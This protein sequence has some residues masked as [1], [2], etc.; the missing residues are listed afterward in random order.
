VLRCP[1]RFGTDLPLLALTRGTRLGPY[2]TWAAAQIPST[3]KIVF[4]PTGLGDPIALDR[5]PI[6][7]TDVTIKWFA[8]SSR[9]LYCGREPTM[10]SRC[11]A[12]DIRGGSPAPVTPDE[13]T[14][15]VLDG[16]DRTLLMRRSD[17]SF[18]MMP[19]GGT[20]VDAK[21]FTPGDRLLTWTADRSGVVV[22]D[23]GAAPAKVG[24]V[25]PASGRRSR[26]KE[27]APPDR[28]GVTEVSDV[29]WLP[30]ASGYVYSY[31]HEIGQLYVVSGWQH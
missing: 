18:Q 27:L 20:P 5:G 2:E 11:Y 28:A 1:S 21:G 23:V 12:Q 6:D 29:Y 10:P 25:D 31:Q 19:I 3:L 14:D 26:L 30:N 4:Y 15:A 24:L 8:N 7:L 17:G 22:S 9:V 13:V 16:D